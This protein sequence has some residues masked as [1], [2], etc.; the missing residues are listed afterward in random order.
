MKKKILALAMA[1]LMLMIA[2]V[3]GTLAYFTDSEA[4]S[5]VFAVG[6]VDIELTEVAAVYDK[7]GNELVGRTTQNENGATYTNLMPT[8]KIVKQPKISNVGTNPAYVRVVVTMNN[9]DELNAAIDQYYEAK[10]YTVDQVQE[11]YNKVFDGWGINYNP[12][13][14]VNGQDA[15]G[16]IDNVANMRYYDANKVIDVDF[17]K[18]ASS[19]PST[20]PGYDAPG[21]LYHSLFGIGNMFKSELEQ[22]AANNGKYE[23]RPTTNGWAGYYTNG[24]NDKE[25]R[26][27]YYLQL[28]VGES[29]VLFDGLNVPADF[30]NNA[31]LV[32]GTVI[33]Q[34]AFFEGLEI[35]IKAD[36]IQQEGFETSRAAFEALQAA[37]PID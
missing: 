27:V 6:N 32:D 36:A 2:V 5:N 13:P 10:G 31:T 29:I 4:Q 21:F 8:N 15:R 26:Y 35:S 25:I 34:I 3:G 37:H 11:V 12:R 20:T 18:T 24:M 30:D 22:T 14:G 23:I 17:T 16:V 19:F 7:D 9:V 28:Q 33:N 1:A